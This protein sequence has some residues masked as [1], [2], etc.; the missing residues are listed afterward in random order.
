MNEEDKKNE[1]L[2]TSSQVDDSRYLTSPDPKGK[3]NFPVD[4]A[5]EIYTRNMKAVFQSE[6]YRTGNCPFPNIFRH[7]NA[8]E[9][10]PYPA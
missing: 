4:S 9:T 8:I 2:S 10:S 7:Q 5:L 6:F 1:K 3:A